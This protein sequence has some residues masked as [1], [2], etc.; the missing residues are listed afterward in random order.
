[1]RSTV[2]GAKYTFC[3]KGLYQIKLQ[4]LQM[5]ALIPNPSPSGEGSQIQSPSPPGRGI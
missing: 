1:M 3:E 5:Y 2:L 4:M